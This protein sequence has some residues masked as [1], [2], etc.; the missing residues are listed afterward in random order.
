M[1]A[2]S[3]SQ[4]R[5][6]STTWR[7]VRVF[8]SSTFQDMQAERDH[9]VRF[10]FPA[11]RERLLPRR[12]HL[13]DV[14]LR[15]GVTSEQDASE[16]C[17][18]IIKECRPRFLCM[19]GGRYGTIPAGKE[20]SITAD[21]IHF[22]VLEEQR[23]EI[24]A[25]F[26]FRHGAVTEQMNRARPGAVR[27][28][29]GSAKARKLAQLK[30]AIR[31]GKYRRIL[32]RPHWQADEQRLLDLRA[33]GQAVAR[34]LLATIDDELGPET[35][36]AVDELAEEC[37]AMEAFA[38]ERAER[39]VLGSREAVL[40]ELLARAQGDGGYICVTGATGSGKSALLAHFSE[41]ETFCD[42]PSTLL[43][44]HFVGASTGSTDVRR[45]LLRLCNELKKNCPDIR[46]ELPDEAN[47]LRVAFVDFLEKASQR[48]RVVILI[49]AVNEFETTPSLDALRWLPDE[50]SANACVILSAPTGPALEA[51]DQH[52]KRR[53]IMLEPLKRADGEAII[54]R[55]RQRYGKRFSADQC[56]TL[57][58][59]ADAGT[60]LYLLTALEELRTLG[61]YEEITRRIAEL[62][63]TT[64][65]LFT[66]TLERLESDDGFRS[67]AGRK[68]GKELVTRFAALL[69]ASRHGLS[70]RELTVLLDPGDPQGNVAALLRLLRSYLML[71]GELLDFYHGQF[72]AAASQKYLSQP[73]DRAQ[74]HHALARF[75]V[76]TADS[77]GDRT[78]RSPQSGDSVIH[79]LQEVGFHACRFAQESGKAALLFTLAD[80][81][82][83]RQRHFEQCGS[84]TISMEL[85]GYSLEVA[86]TVPDPVKLV[87]F[88]MLRSGLAASLARLYL[89][90]L[91]EV[92]RQEQKNSRELA[93]AV[94]R[95]I[96]EPAHRRL[97]LLLMAWM[98]RND[99]VCKPLVLDLIDEALSIDARAEASQS[100][101]LLEMACGLFQDGFD[102]AVA[103][104]DRV[105]TSPIRESYQRVW[106]A[107][108]VR[109]LADRAAP[110]LTVPQS[111]W[112]E[113]QQILQFTQGFGASGKS[114]ANSKRSFESFEMKLCDTFGPFGAAGAYFSMAC[115]RLHGG[116]DRL[117]EVMVT[118]GIYVCAGIRRPALRTLTAMSQVFAA[119]G[120]ADMAREHEDRVR[121]LTK[122]AAH[123]ARTAEEKARLDDELRESTIVT[124]GAWRA[125]GARDL[126]Q[127]AVLA[128]GKTARAISTDHPDALRSLSNAR[129]LVAEDQLQLLPGVLLELLT[130]ADNAPRNRQCEL[131]LAT[132]CLA[133]ACHAEAAIRDSAKALAR[134]GLELDPVFADTPAAEVGR[135]GK[136]RLDSRRGNLVSQELVPVVMILAAADPRCV[137]A[138]ALSLRV[139]GHAQLLYELVWR[140][141]D[142]GLPISMLDPLLCELVRLPEHSAP[143][144]RQISDEVLS[145]ARHL[146][147]PSGLGWYY[148]PGIMLISAWLGGVLMA[149]GFHAMRSFGAVAPL[150]AVAL[151]AGVLGAFTD[152]WIWQRIELWARPEKSRHLTAELGTIAAC[153]A[154]ALWMKPQFPEG[155]R[156]SGAVVLGVL[157][158]LAAEGLLTLILGVRGLLF[159]P[160]RAKGVVLG[161]GLACLVA[162]LTWWTAPHWTLGRNV[163]HLLAGL[164]LGGT[165]AVSAALNIF[166]KHITCVRHFGRSLDLYADD[167]GTRR[168]NPG[169]TEE[170]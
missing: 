98:L 125:P 136:P 117:A 91:P 112:K 24:Y 104:L 162:G 110:P 145:T 50:L 88:T 123:M 160:W 153:W 32:Y 71:R 146:T 42:R 10:V 27:E 64:N 9:L 129:L 158:A 113:L 86:A 103:L 141:A 56:A 99:P 5:T 152:L 47:K 61:T 59:K 62:P 87:H 52:F 131:L 169:N 45:T 55:F 66:W 100:A 89:Y 20:L 144:L 18:E 105:P 79:A 21:E 16:I 60:P 19:L 124:D 17:R 93:R 76:K 73:S 96:P 166:P 85:I 23:R 22:G 57:L 134:H 67:A 121:T 122:T 167:A 140:M 54:E 35:V 80:D 106:S 148:Y 51:L 33:F 97:S 53:V 161:S 165:F 92:I 168:T 8:I 25:L 78:W 38:Q 155:L 107:G 170:N 72:R 90:R 138:V 143:D 75:F 81:P 39:F 111:E 44:R 49:D 41:Q 120:E 13:V 130:A 139:S 116:N 95:L 68:V 74:A 70:Q 46:A 29:R 37:A 36:G 127:Q 119:R 159:G 102:R 48:K 114:L 14:D 126:Y 101:L 84:P 115:E 69:S 65:E 30:R 128:G 151:A 40:N 83:L 147:I 63:P 157:A 149:A 1:G 150:A 142:M 6:Q 3:L 43:I 26:Y 118:R 77:D 156:H 164:F 7:T 109:E 34:D 2:Q 137:A 31:N 15:W 163:Q 4:P 82:Q 154:V 28:P 12:I 132:H 11:L 133:R 108:G 94:I 58:A 135:G